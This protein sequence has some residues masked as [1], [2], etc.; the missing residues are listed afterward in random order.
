[1]KNFEYIY[2]HFKNGGEV[3]WNDPD[4]IEGNDYRVTYI[5]DISNDEMADRFTPI[6]I[7]YNGG[8]SEAEVFLHELIAIKTI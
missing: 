4:P 7:H 2:R 3:I 1:M 5:E 6:L 8:V